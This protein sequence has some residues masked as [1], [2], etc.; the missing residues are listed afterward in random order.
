MSEARIGEVLPLWSMLPFAGILLSIAF[1]PLV[2][3]RSW[4]RHYAWI[5]LA[6]ALAFAVPFVAAYRAEALRE[7]AQIYLV[8][9]VPF[10]V[11][12][13]G[14]FVLGG[15]IVV[16][17]TLPGTPL[18]NTGLLLAGTVLASWIGTTGA[19]MLL[20][21]PVLRANANRRHGAHVVVFF[22]FL[23]ANIGGCLTPL[24]DPPLFLGFLHGVP[25]F[26]TLRLLP[27]LVVGAVVLLAV[28]YLL[29]R[30]YHRKEGT[31]RPSSPAEPLRIVGV[32]NL[33][34]LGGVVG[35][36]LLSGFWKGG[37]VH[38]PG[39]ELR[40]EGLVRDALIV[41]MGALS[42]ALTPRGLRRENGFTWGPI[43]EVAVLFAAIFMTILPAIAIL[44]A[45]EG[46]RLG[47]LVGAVEKPWQYFWMAGGLSSFLDNAPTYLTFFHTLLV[48]FAPGIP[49][50]AAVPR[51]LGEHAASLEAVAAGA[52]FMGAN[53]YVGNAPNFMVKRIAE[54]AGV[55]MPSFFGYIFRWSLPVL[56]PLFLGMGFFF[57]S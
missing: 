23:V 1:L 10:V 36:V 28:F 11:L 44:R 18:V 9:Y 55:A 5:S 52:V 2:A 34:L 6:W 33:L 54:E 3:S 27:H 57:R 15:G 16:R 47:V 46:G 38:L 42:L 20:I 26:W 19:A 8:D 25:F 31:G 50:A 7:I 22:I 39:V 24:G 41:L 53:T 37:S 12:L 48:R 51:I 21:R 13:G 40:V 29:D 32:A 45:G 4:H 35:A 30:H 49:E 56:V 17:G 14:L 43:R